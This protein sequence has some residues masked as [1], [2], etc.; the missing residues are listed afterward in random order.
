MICQLYSSISL[1]RDTT[2]TF[3]KK[4]QIEQSSNIWEN[5]IKNRIWIWVQLKFGEIKFM[6][7]VI[8]VTKYFTQEKADYLKF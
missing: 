1:N 3:G 2:K 7:Q 4:I 8:S 6:T 5:L